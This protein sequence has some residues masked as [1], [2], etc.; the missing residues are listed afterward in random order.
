MTEQKYPQ[1]TW[2]VCDGCMQ[3]VGWREV[4]IWADYEHVVC[5]ECVKREREQ[6]P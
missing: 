2:Y 1:R 4:A 3:A 6:K 5:R